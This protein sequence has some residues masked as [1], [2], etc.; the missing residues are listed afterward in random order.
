MKKE[1]TPF[2]KSKVGLVVIGVVVIGIIFLAGSEYKAY[3]VRKAIKEVF[4]TESEKPA[5]NKNI[6]EKKV[7]EEFQLA[8]GTI[9]INSF[10][11]KQMLNNEFGSPVV[12]KENTK[13]VIVNLNVTNTTS[14]KITFSAN[15][16][17]LIDNQ[18]RTFET[19]DDTIGNVDNYLEM[20][21]L[22]PSIME[23]GVL[24]YELPNDATSYAFE[25]DKGGTNDRYMVKLK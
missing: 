2:L 3:Q 8:M 9:K 23:N 18:K 10:E 13:F 17:D 12:A 24:V 4:N 1:E 5:Q 15:T 25:I 7:G 22:S 16:I 21:D 6:I 19:F 20:R 11:E 14:E